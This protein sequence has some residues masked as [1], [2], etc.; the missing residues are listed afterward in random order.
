MQSTQRGSRSP[1]SISDTSFRFSHILIKSPCCAALE[2]GSV[3]TV[4]QNRSPN[5]VNLITLLSCSTFDEVRYG[6]RDRWD[7]WGETVMIL[8]W[9]WTMFYRR[10]TKRT[11]K[12]RT[13]IEYL[14]EKDNDY[15]LVLLYET[16]VIETN[17]IVLL[18]RKTGNADNKS[19]ILVVV[20]MVAGHE[21]PSY[22]LYSLIPGFWSHDRWAKDRINDAWTYDPSVPDGSRRLSQR[23]NCGIWVSDKCEDTSK[24]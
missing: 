9:N 14:E 5:S 24:Y 3:A 18:L 17:T 23:G 16:W 19:L 22:L 7:R 2:M 21:I 12:R 6:N 20:I 11:L 4:R 15:Y 8:L 1:E 13:E 10:K